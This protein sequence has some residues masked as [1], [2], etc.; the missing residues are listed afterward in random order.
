MVL[1][2]RD[3]IELGLN[4]WCIWIQHSCCFDYSLHPSPQTP[5]TELKESFSKIMRRGVFLASGK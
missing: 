3:G 4:P 5:L 2:C 1:Q